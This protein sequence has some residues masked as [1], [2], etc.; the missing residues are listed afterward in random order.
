MLERTNS[1]SL[2]ESLLKAPA[3]SCLLVT[4]RMPN[5]CKKDCSSV[6]HT[7]QISIMDFPCP[8]G[9]LWTEFCT[10]QGITPTQYISSSSNLLAITITF[11]VLQ[12]VL[13]NTNPGFFMLKHN[14]PDSKILIIISDKFKGT[15][16]FTWLIY[17]LQ[18]RETKKFHCSYTSSATISVCCYFPWNFLFSTIKLGL[19]QHEMQN[20]QTWHS[21]NTDIGPYFMDR[22]TCSEGWGWQH[23]R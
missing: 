5:S 9:L 11:S 14:I 16:D 18:S 21:G 6:L 10:F 7:N 17:I 3:V 2:A 19:T 15:D 22:L 20:W 1:M 13:S 8:F 4:I 12:A 23:Q